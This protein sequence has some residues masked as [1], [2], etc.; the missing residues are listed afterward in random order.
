MSQTD[1]RSGRGRGRRW[2]PLPITPLL[3][4]TPAPPGQELRFP[5]AST[6]RHYPEQAAGASRAPR[7]GGSGP[8]QE[9]TPRR[10]HRPGQGPHLGRPS[11]QGGAERG[12][13][14]AGFPGFKRSLSGPPGALAPFV[15]GVGAEG[16]K[17]SPCKSPPRSSPEPG[18]SP[19]KEPRQPGASLR[20]PS[21]RP[22]PRGAGRASRERGGPRSDSGHCCSAGCLGRGRGGSRRT[23]TKRRPSAGSR[24]P[25]ARGCPVRRRRGREFES[26]SRKGPRL[27]AAPAHCQPLAAPGDSGL[28]GSQRP[29]GSRGRAGCSGREG[30][31]RGGPGIFPVGG[32]SAAAGIQQLAARRGPGKLRGAA[33]GS[34]GGEGC[35]GSCAAGG[36]RRA[37]AAPGQPQCSQSRTRT[38]WGHPGVTYLIAPPP[39]GAPDRPRVPYCTHRKRGFRLGVR[40]GG[41]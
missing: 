5:T 32:D 16:R 26:R 40:C 7:T 12:R 19:W 39:D 11:A 29:A 9:S 18:G 33:S 25:G 1:F 34:R 22:H 35:G 36:P 41:S 6:V 27:P 20:R 31:G 4:L 2:F 10:A 17:T 21:P 8:S 38:W 3:A 23:L 30:R 28:R 14:L 13:S 37:R 24:T 15:S